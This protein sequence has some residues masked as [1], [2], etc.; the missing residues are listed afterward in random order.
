MLLAST[1]N[2]MANQ[3]IIHQLITVFNEPGHM[4]VHHW[5]HIYD[6]EWQ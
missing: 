1:E 4:I 5:A 2:P 3:F 6:I